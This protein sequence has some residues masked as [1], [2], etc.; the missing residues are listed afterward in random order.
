MHNYR[1]LISANAF[2]ISYDNDVL[3]LYSHEFDIRIQLNMPDALEQTVVS[4]FQKG[5]RNVS[6]LCVIGNK[7][8]DTDDYSGFLLTPFFDQGIFGMIFENMAIPKLR[9]Q[10]R[11]MEDG[12]LKGYFFRSRLTGEQMYFA[13]PNPIR[14]SNPEMLECQGVVLNTNNV[15]NRLQNGASKF[16]KIEILADTA[17]DPR[18]IERNER[19]LINL[20]SQKNVWWN[21]ISLDIVKS[22]RF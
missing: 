15:G 6:I 17:Y 19:I 3:R 9:F 10:A 2:P 7:I 22:R 20:T 18:K 12:I 1:G 8:L 14:W 5:F 11:H 13:A 21:Y 16:P 4:F